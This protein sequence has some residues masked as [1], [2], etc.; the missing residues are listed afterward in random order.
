MEYISVSEEAKNSPSNL[1]IEKIIE[2]YG[3][4]IFNIAYK[5]SGKT[6]QAEDIAQETFIKAWKHLNELKDHAALKYWLHTICINEFRLFFPK[7]LL[8]SKY[9][10]SLP[11]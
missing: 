5:L 1:S 3:T 6:E 4:Y 8:F 7:S 11:L 2:E 10:K 9:R